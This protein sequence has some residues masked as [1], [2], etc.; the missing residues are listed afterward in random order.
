MCKKRIRNSTNTLS[1]TLTPK[2]TTHEMPLTPICWSFCC[3]GCCCCCC[4]VRTTQQMQFLLR[5]L[6]L[7]LCHCCS[8]ALC[9]F[10]HPLSLP[11]ARKAKRYQRKTTLHRSCTGIMAAAVERSWQWRQPGRH[12]CSVQSFPGRVGGMIACVCVGSKRGGECN[13]QIVFDR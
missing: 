1:H 7:L 13:L 12:L 11:C 9:A 3:C 8:F 2:P 6:L 10:H 5:L 4:S